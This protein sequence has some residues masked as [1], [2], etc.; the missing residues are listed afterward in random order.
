MEGL[1]IFLAII[2]LLLFLDL[3]VLHKKDEIISLNSGLWSSGFYI[4][5]SCIFGS[6]LWYHFGSDYGMTFFAGY[7]IEKSL[8][9]D[10]IFVIAAIFAHFKI[11]DKY[12][13]KVLFWG[14]LTA[15]LL[16]GIMIYLGL[17]IVT[18]FSWVLYLFALFLIFMGLQM[19]LVEDKNA[20]KKI[21]ILSKLDKYIPIDHLYDGHKFFLYK[22]NKLY[23]T[24]LL[25]SLIAVE[26][27]D[28]LF[29]VDSIPAIFSITTDVYI[30]YTSNIF[31]ILGMRSLYFALS[32]VHNNFV[33]V[34]YGIAAA[35]CFIGIKVLLSHT[36]Y[37]INFIYTFY[38][39]VSAIGL[40]VVLSIYKKH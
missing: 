22:N 30:V 3:F 29:A 33:Y 7:L 18:N 1:V 24:R 20:S 23:I 14:I 13:H 4:L 16:R 10:N 27:I 34:K 37:A 38:F 40:S 5:I 39:I 26:F 28:I 19:F 25:I 12:Q 31:A 11:Q 21:K 15:I 8:S 35:L 17:A 2:F 6:W 9:L 32:Y 36:E